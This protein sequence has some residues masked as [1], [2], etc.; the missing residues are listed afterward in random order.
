FQLPNGPLYN[1]NGHIG[2]IDENYDIDEDNNS[3]Q[4]PTAVDPDQR[5]ACPFHKLDPHKYRRCEHYNLTSWPHTH[6]HLRR[7]NVL[8]SGTKYSSYCP[9]CRIKFKTR[10]AKHFHV[11][12]KKC[13]AA[14]MEETGML[15]PEEFMKLAKRGR[16]LSNEQKWHAAWDELFPFLVQPPSA[17]FE[18]HVD[19]L[20]RL[21]FGKIRYLF[22]LHDSAKI[23]RIADRIFT[24]PAIP[25]RALLSYIQVPDIDPPLNQAPGSTYITNPES[26]ESHICPL[27]FVSNGF[28][29]PSLDRDTVMFQSFDPSLQPMM[30]NLLPEALNISDLNGMPIDHDFY[31]TLTR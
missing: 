6:Q 23:T 19:L 24:L 12:A 18:S 3:D 21:A 7:V 5:F 20:Y 16:G 15:L 27:S 11:R 17:Y 30:P 4:H 26:N 28:H 13:Q 10:E 9:T 31:D 8:G 14:S 2:E 25:R 22:D 29:T 1:S